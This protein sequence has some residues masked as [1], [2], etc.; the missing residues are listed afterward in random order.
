MT[1]NEVNA[2][3]IK[4]HNAAIAKRAARLEQVEKMNCSNKTKLLWEAKKMLEFA[5]QKKAK[6]LRV[7]EWEA[8]T[9][10]AA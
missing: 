5:E 6:F 2:R 10:M 8:A 3:T 7:I 4:A 1:R 9:G